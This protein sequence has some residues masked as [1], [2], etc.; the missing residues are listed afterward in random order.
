[1][2]P[3]AHYLT[4]G[5]PGRG[6]PLVALLAN[7][8]LLA[9]VIVQVRAMRPPMKTAVARATAAGVA[10]GFD[11]RGPSADAPPLLRLSGPARGDADTLDGKPLRT[12]MDLDFRLKSLAG[13]ST[14]LVMATD[15][16]TPAERVTEALRAA[17]EAGFLETRVELRRDTATTTS[18]GR[19]TLLK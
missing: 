3:R 11:P 4:G 17:A 7:L 1:M 18:T 14:T 15:A 13:R 8:A 5:D 6:L 16:D 2:N 19:K 12:A 9:A 10:R